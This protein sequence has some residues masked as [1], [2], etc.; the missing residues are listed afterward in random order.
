MELPELWQRDL[1]SEP[2]LLRQPDQILAGSAGLYPLRIDKTPVPPGF[3]AKA[4]ANRLVGKKCAGLRKNGTAQSA[5]HHFLQ[6]QV[7][8]GLT[9]QRDASSEQP[10][11]AH[12]GRS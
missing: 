10:G 5:G 6:N 4:E 7:H 9:E 8:G 2:V 12:P 11:A 3:S 1:L